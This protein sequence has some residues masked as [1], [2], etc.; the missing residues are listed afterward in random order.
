MQ[1][2]FQSVYILNATTDFIV[3]LIATTVD[4]SDDTVMC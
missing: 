2:K 4:V 1:F 3:V